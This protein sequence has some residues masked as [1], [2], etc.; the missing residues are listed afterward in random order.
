MRPLR[1]IE[2]QE[3]RKNCKLLLPSGIFCLPFSVEKPL[4]GK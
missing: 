1:K 3:K 4:R 2:I